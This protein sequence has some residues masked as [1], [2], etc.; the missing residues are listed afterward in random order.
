[1]KK[2]NIKKFKE[3]QVDGAHII[4][5]K[6]SHNFLIEN[7]IIPWGCVILDPRPFDGVSTHGIVRKDLLNNPNP[8]TNYIIASMTNPEVTKHI[9]NNKG[10]LLGWHAFTNSLTD[11][12]ELEGVQMITGGTCSAMRSVGVMHVLGFREFHIFGMDCCYEG[13]PKDVEEKD[14]YGKKKWLKVGILNEKTG[15]EKKF[16]TTGE[17][18]ALAQDFE[19]LLERDQEVD[20]DLYVYGDGMVPT[21][22]KT[23][24][25]KIK[26]SFDNKYT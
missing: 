1:M 15:K 21:I 7:G 23:S 10:K 19:S 9:K 13:T 3:L 16:Y 2:K 20:M 8:N 6:H 14:I 18:L 12:K 17:L 24:N 11:M 26:Q 25:Y 22:F 5:V 4:C